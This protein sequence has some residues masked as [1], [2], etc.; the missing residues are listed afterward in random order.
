MERGTVIRLALVI[1]A[2]AIVA[3]VITAICS[4]SIG[5]E[6]IMHFSSWSREYVEPLYGGIT[7]HII[8]AFGLAFISFQYRSILSFLRRSIQSTDELIIGTWNIYR[9]TKSQGE[10]V[11]LTD[12]W[13][14]RRNL[15]RK[16]AVSMRS[17]AKNKISA[18][19]G[20]IIYNERDRFS[21]L[22]EGF[23]HKEQSLISFSPRI[24]VSGDTRTLGLG[25]GDDADYI[26]S[27]R[28][29]LASRTA[30]PHEH[31]KE[32][33][34]DASACIRKGDEQLI[35]LPSHVISEIFVRHP[36]PKIQEPDQQDHR[37]VH[38]QTYMPLFLSPLLRRTP[39]AAGDESKGAP[40]DDE[41]SALT[42]DKF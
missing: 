19:M 37:G 14:I 25:L 13:T 35:Q 34:N 6:L 39:T 29:Y 22:L 4:T 15:S 42:A 3:S 10:I 16:Y 9:Y 11:L 28:I 26:L 24:P 30:L 7:E 33:L 36:L 27:S 2:L 1:L 40:A 23:N 20:W 17:S 38:W 18:Y 41:P 32:I 8:A 5:N 31:V 21:V 12:V